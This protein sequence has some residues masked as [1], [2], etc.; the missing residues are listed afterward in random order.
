MSR[1]DFLQ[2]REVNL[3]Q[4]R[5]IVEASV[6]VMKEVQAA[7]YQKLT[8]VTVLNRKHNGASAADMA[9][10]LMDELFWGK[11]PVIVKQFALQKHMQTIPELRGKVVADLKEKESEILERS[12]VKKMLQI[13]PSSHTAYQKIALSTTQREIVCIE[14]VKE[15]KKLCSDR[16]E[17]EIERPRP[18][19]QLRTIEIASNF[20]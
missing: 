13:K 6:E 11:R 16:L 19:T 12:D 5:E 4:W 10:G 15:Q 14:Q 17:K 20:D 3:E 1:E 9:K 7:F 2:I 8:C 18:Q